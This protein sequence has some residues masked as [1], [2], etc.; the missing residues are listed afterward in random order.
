MENILIGLLVAFVIINIAIRIADNYLDNRKFKQFPYQPRGY[1]LSQTELKFFR[2]LQETVSDRAILCPKVR[3]GDVF[4][5]TAK[6]KNFYFY[7]NRINQK[8]V[9]FL[10]CDPDTMRPIVAIELDDNSHEREDRKARD[11]FVDQVYQA[12]SLPLLHVPVQRVYKDLEIL[13]APYLQPEPIIHSST[14]PVCPRCSRPMIVRKANSGKTVGEQ[15]WVCSNY[16]DCRAILRYQ[17]GTPS[18]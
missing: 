1:I 2:V 10:L 9:D 13:L 7:L 3:L 14:R 15:F 11:A 8:H 18:A 17:A 4:S 16:P 6:G 12:A 5:V